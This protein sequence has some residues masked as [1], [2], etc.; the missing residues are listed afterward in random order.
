MT[1]FRVPLERLSARDS[2][3]DSG[4]VSVV[5]AGV[6]GGRSLGEISNIQ[7]LS[8]ELNEPTSYS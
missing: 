7:S 3:K 8:N 5:Q 1:R 6:M 2:S 4:N